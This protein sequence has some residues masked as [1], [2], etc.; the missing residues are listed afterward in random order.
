MKGKILSKKLYEKHG[1][2]T[3]FS[4]FF[5]FLRILCK[6]EFEEVSM[7]I[8]IYFDNVAVTHPV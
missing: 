4:S 7:L 6:K 8:L 2:E 5:C 1:L 3:S